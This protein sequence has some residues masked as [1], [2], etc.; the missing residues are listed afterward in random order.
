MTNTVDAF[1]ALRALVALSKASP[2]GQTYRSPSSR[3]PRDFESSHRPLATMPNPRPTPTAITPAP[4]TTRPTVR[5]V[6]PR[7][8]TGADTGA[9]TGATGLGS[10]GGGVCTMG[11]GSGG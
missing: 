7:F 9:A 6:L 4:P 2:G 11:G 3:Q 1:A 10:G 8:S 5:W